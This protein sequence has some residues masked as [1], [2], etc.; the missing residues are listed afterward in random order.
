[1]VAMNLAEPSGSSPELKPPGS[2]TPFWPSH[3][4]QKKP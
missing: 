3:L 4:G 1:M 2:M